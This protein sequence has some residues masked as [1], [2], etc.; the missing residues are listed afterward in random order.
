MVGRARWLTLLGIVALAAVAAVV[1]LE[2]GSSQTNPSVTLNLVEGWNNMAYPGATRPVPQ[3]LAAIAGRYDAVYY[4]DAPTARWL[5]YS[6]AAP[7]FAN[8][9]QQLSQYEAYWIHMTA[10]A[11]LVVELALPP[12]PAP[13]PGPSPFSTQRVTADSSIGFLAIRGE[14]VNGT[15]AN[16]LWP[17]VF[18]T[19]LDASG[20]IIDARWAYAY[21]DLVPPGQAAPFEVQLTPP[22]QAARYSLQVI[23][24]KT[25]APAATGLNISGLGN[26]YRKQQYM[27]VSARLANNSA[28]FYRD[29]KVAGSMYDANG[30]VAVAAVGIVDVG[31]DAVLSPGEMTVFESCGY[32]PN[33]EPQ[34]VA[35][36]RLWPDGHLAQA[37]PTPTPVPTATATPTA[38]PTAAPTGTPLPYYTPIPNAA[39]VG[40]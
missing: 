6:P 13:P 18:A 32:A 10:P 31:P 5:G 26:P 40:F 12:L 24:D 11:T 25:Q 7:E 23:W 15:G 1:T 16:A 17:A 14:I 37:P 2:R 8:D 35:D 33:L 30:N 36:L 27:C 4:W 20:K 21:R 3:A 28:N 34:A 9:L 29:V 39:G 38:T 19:A 22:G